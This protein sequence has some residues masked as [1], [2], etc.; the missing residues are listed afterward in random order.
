M[1]WRSKKASG[2]G[3]IIIIVAVFL[4]FVFFAMTMFKPMNDVND[5]IQDSDF[6][7]TE[8]KDAADD[9]TSWTPNFLD[10]A[11]IIMVFVFCIAMY[12]S[13]YFIDSYPIF[14]GVFLILLVLVIVAAAKLSNG[15]VEIS[16]TDGIKEA[17]P[18]YPKC[19]YLTSHLAHFVLLIGIVEGIV[20][21][22]KWRT[23]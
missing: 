3:D 11:L 14:A 6:Y 8:G 21:F 15:Y 4:V 1:I 23:S 20:L 13:S 16:L 9:L 18:A 10:T 22:A 7:T 12:V 17:V 2:I 19:H 5:A